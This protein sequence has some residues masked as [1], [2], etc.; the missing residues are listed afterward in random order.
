[1]KQ[2]KILIGFLPTTVVKPSPKIY[3]KLRFMDWVTVFKIPL[4]IQGI[5][6]TRFPPSRRFPG[7][8]GESY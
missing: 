3:E 6:Y 1:L 7:E 8:Q 4:L 2:A 5:F